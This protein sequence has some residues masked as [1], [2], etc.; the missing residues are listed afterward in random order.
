MEAVECGAAAL[1]SILGYYGR[2][3]PLEELRVACGVSRDGSKAL[4]M[5]RAA[6]E[7]G[8][9]ADGW[10]KD[11]QELRAMPLPSI[12]F[13]RFNHFVVLEGFG[14]RR[15]HLNDPA[16]GPLSVPFEEFDDAYTGVV[17]TFSPAS[18]FRRGGRPPSLF[19]ALRARLAG[20]GSALAYV[21]LAGLALVIPG[22]VA[23]T[24]SQVF[25]DEYLVKGLKDW[26]VPLLWIMALTAGVKAF[27]TWLQQSYLLRLQVKLAVSTSSRFF[28]HILRLPVE[29]FCQRFGG[30]I[31]SRVALN[32]TVAQLL[33]GQLATTVVSLLT[34]VFFLL[35]MLSYDVL[36]TAIGVA[37]A[38]LN[39][40]ALKLVS[41]W[42]V[43][44]NRRLL[45]EQG[46]L[47][48]TAMAGL[49]I[50]ETVKATG[51]EDDFFVR[52]AGLQAKVVNASQ[53]LGRL[54]QG[55]TN[56]PTLLSALNA[57]AILCV[58]AWCVMAGQLSVGMLVAFQALMA[59]FIGPFSSLVDM[60]ST[61]QEAEG[62]MNRLDD[63]LRADLDVRHQP[64]ADAAAR[65]L[66]GFRGA[67]LEGRLEL[68]NITFG[69]SRLEDPLISQFSLKLEPGRRVAIVGASGSGKSTLANLI[70]GL[71][72]PWS[73]EI[74][75]DGLPRAAIPTV[76][77]AGSVARVSQEIFLFEG[78][79]MDNLTLW[80]ATLP[81]A[82]VFRAA[83]DACIDDVIAA[84]PGGY[85]GWLEEGGANLSGGQRQRLEIARA[86]AV[87]PALLILDEATSALDPVT[88]FQIDRNLRRRGCTC[89]IIAHRLS[90]IRDC[91]EIIVLSRGRVV[92]RGT[93]DEM[94]Q[95][96]GVYADLIHA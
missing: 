54:T 62:Y 19:R 6:R 24:F 8:L 56:V 40:I 77:M 88:E 95:R 75:F 5:L 47:T 65:P 32:D 34:I 66:A 29:F 96:K 42:R 11:L 26:V 3:V 68:R 89:V 33:S 12:V 64:G 13:W 52:F 61:V 74:L 36:L 59:S 55:L 80:D 79:I 14:R 63:V 82:D 30:E 93:H 58:G 18:G 37:M 22:L 70:C 25:V 60:G 16:S 39:M 94:I 78:T 69:Y 76:V 46:R 49:Q 91:D 87:N 41:R 90:T 7:Y 17:L 86:L 48:G 35:L 51:M 23:P 2:F 1:G 92:E 28:W 81:E 44:G 9:E 21:V 43:D 10:K 73:G 50:M 72:T 83:A 45:Q 20:S 84:R 4:N 15:V 38:S 57:A 53:D 31:G 71:Y 27:L 85:H 67:R